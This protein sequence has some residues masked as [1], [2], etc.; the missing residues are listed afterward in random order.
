MPIQF[1]AGSIKVFPM[2]QDQ[3]AIAL[4]WG[5]I[6]EIWPAKTLVYFD[7]NPMWSYFWFS[8]FNS[9]FVICREHHFFLLYIFLTQLHVIYATLV[10]IFHKGK[11]LLEKR[12]VLHPQE[13]G[14]N[15]KCKIFIEFLLSEKYPYVY[16]KNKYI[17]NMSVYNSW[18]KL[19]NK[20]S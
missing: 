15:D 3:R 17:S 4:H 20:D 10:M 19:W 18:V 13:Y 6:G 12:Q 2:Q 7:L 5:L 11:T 16:L 14:K 8:S 9:D 1:I